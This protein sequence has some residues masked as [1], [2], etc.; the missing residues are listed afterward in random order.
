MTMKQVDGDISDSKV[1]SAE[2]PPARRSAIF[3]ISGEYWTISYLGT[4]F[5]LKDVKGLIYLQHLLQHPGQ[6]FHALDML[7]RAGGATAS[8]SPNAD[9]ASLLES[10]GVT[11]GGLGDAGEMLDAR[12]KQEYKR[13][14][15]E[16]R[17]EREEL[18]EGSDHERAV[19][20]ERELE[21]LAQEL[22]RALGLG[23]RD[24]RMGSAAERA[25]LSVTRAI[26]AA[27][28]K[29]SEHHG[30]LAELLDR[31]IRTGTFCLYTPD[32]NHAISWDFS[33]ETARTPAGPPAPAPFFVRNESRFPPAPANKITF[34]GRN[35]ERAM[36]RH[37]LDQAVRGE[38]RVAFI[39]GAAG[40]GKTRIA[41]EMAAEAW[42]RG[43]L[44]LTGC[45]YDRSD[46]VPFMPFVEILEA[47]LAQACSPRA[48]RDALGNDAGEL[49]RLLPQLQRQFPDIP[50]PLDLT[51]EQSR[52]VL[53]K[54][55]LELLRR[56]TGSSPVLLV[57][58]DLQWADEGTFSLLNYLSRSIA[59]IPVVIVVTYRNDDIDPV[60]RL[61]GTV[62]DLAR[63]GLTGEIKLQGLDQDSV[64]DMIRALSGR[65]PPQAVVTSIYTGT[66]GNPFFVE[67][68][69]KHLVERGELL[70]LDGEFRPDL[71]LADTDVPQSLRV[72]IGQRLA[73][74]GT[75]TR[76]TLGTAAV[77]GRSF[78]FQLLE[79]ATGG[80]T[81][82]LLDQIEE[83]EKAGIISSNLDYP[84]ARF[85]FSHELIR[86]YVLGELSSPRLQRA[87]LGIAD[88]MERIYGNTVEDHANDLAYHLL[89]AGGTADRTKAIRYLT[90]S[91]KRARMQ[92]ALTEAEGFYRRALTV[93]AT[94]PQTPERD[95]HEFALRQALGA[96]LVSARAQ[97]FERELMTELRQVDF[98]RDEQLRLLVPGL[99]L[100]KLRSG[101]TI[102]REGDAGDS[103][104]IIR[105][106]E[107]EV[108][109][110]AGGAHEVH[111][112]NLKPSAFFGE[113]ALMTGGPRNAT[114]RART[115]AELLEVSREGSV[116][117]F[118]SHPEI[119]GKIRRMIEL[120]M[121]ERRE[122]L[123]AGS[124]GY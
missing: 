7:N 81:D 121:S 30:R 101:E 44:I 98:L 37:Y 12:A 34:V 117:L 14:L 17:K 33:V 49:S 19:K 46:C 120:R 24:R 9:V 1:Q 8:L 62:Y 93:L 69:F 31:A 87:H 36:L 64:A 41:S 4:T 103:L 58:E 99:R 80:D 111:I 104:Y 115:E 65:E 59:K 66:E 56:V 60:G 45:C 116:E 96:I 95:Q 10:V 67:E 48:F 22:G 75:S 13:R 53:F 21:F 50:P 39:A 27:V 102:L 92:S 118:K 72:V 84:D 86:R 107:V 42:T 52:R 68:L 119:A 43:F 100:L 3:A 54:A 78:T 28:Q 5:S 88:A 57:V 51:P 32:A 11:V 124:S 35:A 109:A 85:H 82:F 83:A 61:A 123:V 6:E 90:L 94:M 25:R 55:L 38:G 23:G 73:R 20:V 26:R 91:A 47:A 114:V 40:V 29:I 71:Q 18:L 97:E 105:A 74:L 110:H 79:A 76:K 2:L 122:S 70:D 63:A 106:G 77:I 89:Q 113:M 16:L 15:F 112:R 108:L